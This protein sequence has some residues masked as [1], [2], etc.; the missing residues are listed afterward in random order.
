MPPTDGAAVSKSGRSAKPASRWRK[1]ARNASSEDV[2]R[3]FK[4]TRLPVPHY[5]LVGG[6]ANGAMPDPAVAWQAGAGATIFILSIVPGPPGSGV[7]VCGDTFGMGTGVPGEM[8]LSNGME[9]APLPPACV[10]PKNLIEGRTA[11]IPGGWICLLLRMS[12]SL[13]FRLPDKSFR[14]AWQ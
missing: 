1:A 7:C 11:N 14:L 4:F 2:S 9:Q 13:C 12:A 8:A 3:C 5:G 10:L 6:V